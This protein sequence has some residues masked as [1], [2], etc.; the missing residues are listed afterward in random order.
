MKW[1]HLGLGQSA[2]FVGAAAMFDKSHAK[3]TI[4][5]GVL[6]AVMMY[7]L[8]SHAKVAGIRSNLPGTEQY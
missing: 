8:Y 4:I 3:P 2:I 6:A 7:G 5:G 1:V